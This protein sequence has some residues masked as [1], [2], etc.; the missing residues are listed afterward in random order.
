[1]RDQTVAI[2]NGEMKSPGDL[3]IIRYNGR[4]YQWK[5]KTIKPDGR[6]Q[7]ERHSVQPDTGE[8]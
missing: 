4:I 8:F 3:I 1:M 5:L 6:I 2:I 7:L